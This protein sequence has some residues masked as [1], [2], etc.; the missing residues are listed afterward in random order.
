MPARN[1][2]LP[3][4]LSW[5]LTRTDV[6]TALGERFAEVDELSFG[7]HPWGDGTLLHVG[8]TPVVRANYGSGVHPS[9]WCRIHVSVCPLPAADRAAARRALQEHVLAELGAWID[10]ARHAPETW[11]LTWHS[12][13]WRLVAGAAAHRDDR[14]PYR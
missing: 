11:T 1:R 2:R 7:G 12:R 8:W 3:R 10:N 6:Q 14:Q 9:R 4:H 13:S 5:P